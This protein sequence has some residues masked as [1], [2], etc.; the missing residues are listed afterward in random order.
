MSFHPPME[1]SPARFHKSERKLAEPGG[2][3]TYTPENQAKF[4][5]NVA[6]YPADQ[7]KSAIL[8]ALYLAQNAAGLSDGGGDARTSRSRFG[9][10]PAEVE[11]VVSY[12]T[13]FFTKPVG[14]YVRERLP[15]AVV[16]AARRRA[17]DRGAERGDRHQAGRDR[18]QP[19]RSR[20]SRWNASARAIARR[21]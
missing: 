15:H 6:R 10:T 19:A 11:D 5:A 20:C 14:K 9:C 1:Y 12:Y 8:Y 3:F 13:M 21:W 16:R 2:E 4:D 18:C 7:R 17:R